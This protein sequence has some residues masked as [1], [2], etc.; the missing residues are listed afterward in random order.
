MI[1]NYIKKEL[2]QKNKVKTIEVIRKDTLDSIEMYKYDE[3]GILSS[4]RYINTISKYFYNKDNLLISKISFRN[5]VVRRIINY[6]YDK[7]NNLVSKY[8]DGYLVYKLFKD[9]SKE[10][11]KNDR[12]VRKISYNNKDIEKEEFYDE[13]G[14]VC[15]TCIYTGI[16]GESVKREDIDSIT[17][18]FYNEKRICTGLKRISK[19]DNKILRELYFEHQ[20]NIKITID[21]SLNKKRVMQFD[22][23]GLIIKDTY[24]TDGE[25]E[26]DY[27]INYTYYENI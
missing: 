9:N 2:I 8:I 25:I 7:D 15:N 12:L 20:D 11:Y 21:V 5:G 1:I 17:E 13:K 18:Y 4:S 10:Y 6:T 27:V 22:N 16:V 3:N 23:N 24:Y 19:K 14:N 26:S